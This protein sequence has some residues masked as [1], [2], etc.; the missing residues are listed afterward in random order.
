MTLAGLL[1]PGSSG[2]QPDASASAVQF[3]DP[4]APLDRRRELAVARGLAARL[5]EAR[6]VGAD[7]A[8]AGPVL[9]IA[10]DPRDRRGSVILVGPA[11]FALGEHALEAALT[12]TLVVAGFDGYVVQ[13]PLP[14][15]GRRAALSGDAEWSTL[16]E[17]R[18]AAACR[19]VVHAEQPVFVVVVGTDMNLALPALDAVGAGPQMLKLAALVGIDAV[20]GRTGAA[21]EAEPAPGPS[22]IAETLAARAVPLMLVTTFA[23]PRAPEFTV[24]RELAARQRS[25]RTVSLPELGPRRTG[26]ETGLVQR[27][28]GF[29]HHVLEPE[30]GDSVRAASG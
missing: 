24:A 22:S 29:F 13:A 28:L 11:G 30:D 19:A 17:A 5:P 6:V 21:G 8:K 23:A 25:P 7:D 10:A 9:V 16:L 20:P 14:P 15:P 26:L 18:V 2:A 1:V 27:V 4:P 3:G 12:E